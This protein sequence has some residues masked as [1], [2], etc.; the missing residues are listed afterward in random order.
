MPAIAGAA[1]LKASRIA[2]AVAVEVR[3]CRMTARGPYW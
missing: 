3:R 2:V 1:L